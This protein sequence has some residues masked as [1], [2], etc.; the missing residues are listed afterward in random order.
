MLAKALQQHIGIIGGFQR[1]DQRV[2]SARK[3]ILLDID[4][5]QGCSHFLSNQG[6]LRIQS[7]AQ[8][9]RLQTG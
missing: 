6:S 4:N 5:D 9:N 1:V 8:K 7:I 2:F 3:I